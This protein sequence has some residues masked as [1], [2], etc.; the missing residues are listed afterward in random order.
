MD[1]KIDPLF[2]YRNLNEV[3]KAKAK[4]IAVAFTKFLAELG[5]LEALEG[6]EG[7]VVKTKLQEASF[8]AKKSMVQFP[9]NLD[10]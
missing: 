8:F 4:A 9:A 5:T 2:A 10:E 1:E 3:G 6:R 7:A